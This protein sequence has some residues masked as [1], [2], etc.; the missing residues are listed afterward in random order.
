ME[1]W[2]LP[3]CLLAGK[4]L[5]TFLLGQWMLFYFSLKTDFSLY[6]ELDSSVLQTP[7][8]Y[9]LKAHSQLNSYMNF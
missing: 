3:C 7:F 6:S 1:Q 5:S 8:W 2:E 4:K 9:M